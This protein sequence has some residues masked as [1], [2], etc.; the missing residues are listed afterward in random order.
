MITTTSKVSLIA[1]CFTCLMVFSTYGTSY[2]TVI[3][4]VKVESVYM[5]APSTTHTGALVVL[6]NTTGAAIASTWANN[7]VRRFFL[8]KPLGNQGMAVLLTALSNKTKVGVNIA[9]TAVEYSLINYVGV[10]QVA[11]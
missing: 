6:R 10:S 2:A 1:F 3:C 5:T 9:G 8:S 11:Q 4:T 7:T